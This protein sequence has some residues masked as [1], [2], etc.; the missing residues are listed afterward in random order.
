M[1]VAD[2][3]ASEHRSLTPAPQGEAA[4]GRRGR[5]PGFLLRTEG[6]AL[7]TF[8]LAA[9]AHLDVSW[10]LFA[11]LILVPDV[12]LAGYL[13]G[14]RVGALTYNLTHTL[15]GPTAL[16][17]LGLVTGSATAMAV[18]SIWAAHIG[19]DRAFG[20]GLKYASGFRDTHLQRVA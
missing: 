9:Y 12:G 18:A 17:L 2:P 8:G 4:A 3:S 16:A 11:A 20:F 7:F 1:A 5:G 19:I 14:P 10:W 15:V 13:A 6:A